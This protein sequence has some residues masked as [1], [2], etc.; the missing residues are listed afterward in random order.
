ML[1]FI[2]CEDD[3]ELFF[4][5]NQE[6]G[7]PPAWTMKRMYLMTMGSPLRDLYSFAFPHL[8][9]WVRGDRPPVS[10]R[11]GSRPLEE[12]VEEGRRVVSPAIPISA[13]P[14]P[15]D[16]GVARWI[17]AYRSGDYVGRA[18]WRS[19]M[20]ELNQWWLRAA[21]DDAPS[22]HSDDLPPIIYV[23]EDAVGSRRELCIGAGSHTHYW[24]ESAKAIALELDSLIDSALALPILP[25]P[26]ARDAAVQ[27]GA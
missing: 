9:G 7:Q 13:A 2:Q 4:L 12:R 24:D 3:E 20:P 26:A 16:L 22:R 5:R 21:P 25:A 27:A 17:N 15:Y 23:S 1:N 10:A 8:F 6:R 11:S 18:L 19:N 14:D